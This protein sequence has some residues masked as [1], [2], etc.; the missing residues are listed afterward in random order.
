MSLD[1]NTKIQG[2][3]VIFPVLVKA[4]TAVR[5]GCMLVEDTGAEEAGGDH[6]FLGVAD[7]TVS[8]SAGALGDKTVN[9]RRGV[10]AWFKNS[11][12]DPVL[13]ATCGVACYGESGDTVCVTVGSKGAV[14]TVMRVDSTLGVLVWLG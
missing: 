2:T 7:E 5:A 8:N 14:G 4:A 3:G 11:A 9:V 10:A 12:T 1:V 13:Q 6:K